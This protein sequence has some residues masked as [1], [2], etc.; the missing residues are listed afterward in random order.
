MK[1][2]LFS[3]ILSAIALMALNSNAVSL[4]NFGPLTISWTI[5]EQNE[6]FTNTPTLT[7]T[8]ADGKKATNTVYT[9]KATTSSSN[10]SGTS[11][12]GLIAESFTNI[13]LPRGAKLATDGE[14]NIYVVDS[15]GSNDLITNLSEVLTVTYADSLTAGSA[16]IT[17]NK[18]ET[19]TTYVTNI[20]SAIT[21]NTNLINTNV[22]IIIDVTNIMTNAMPETNM[23]LSTNIDIIS[24]TNGTNA[25]VTNYTYVTNFTY[26]TNINPET[27]I[28]VIGTNITTYTN[29]DTITTA[30]MTNVTT[31]FTYVTNLS[32]STN[33]VPVTNYIVYTTNITTYTTTNTGSGTATWTT[34]SYFTLRYSDPANSNVFTYHGLASTAID[35]N[36]A[37]NTAT[38]NFSVKSGVGSGIIHGKTTLISG[39][40]TGSAKGKVSPLPE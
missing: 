18:V 14:T 15:T 8:N 7:K 36:A 24:S 10:F 5:L 29:I 12:L 30:T 32:Y 13:T 3:T 22:Y 25:P 19:N 23:V 9:Y 40:M 11:L 4:T 38:E 39:T 17:T 6:P 31:K 26:T 33:V 28:Y 1:K 27:N 35:D 2:F 20:T 21:T 16:D 34:T 37:K